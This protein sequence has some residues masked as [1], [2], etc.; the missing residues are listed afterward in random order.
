MS[1]DTDDNGVATSVPVECFLFVGSYKTYAYTSADVPITINGITYSPIAI[2]REK[3][4]IGTHQD[5][6]LD[7]QIVMPATTPLILDYAFQISPPSL[8]LTLYR[9]N[10]NDLTEFVVYWSGPLSSISVSDD[11]GTVQVPSVFSYILSTPVPSHGYQLN[12]GHMLFDARCKVPK[13][14]NSAVSTALTISGVEIVVA[15]VGTFED[16]HCQNGLLENG[17]E[18]RTIVSQIGTT[19]RINY[20]FAKLIVGQQVTATA[21]CNRTAAICGSRFN[22]LLNHGGFR[23]IPLTSPFVTGVG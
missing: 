8:Q 5:D 14:D 22:N 6:N 7:C 19:I 20:P 3:L 9:A 23:Y 15:S 18:S 12:C 21:G 4:S 11:E 16:N 13:S 10:R 1:Y 17:T 2:Q